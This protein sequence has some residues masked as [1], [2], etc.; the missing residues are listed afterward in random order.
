MENKLQ[1]MKNKSRFIRNLR[2]W[3]IAHTDYDIHIDLNK[4]KIIKPNINQID[5]IL[6]DISD[7]MN[8]FLVQ[9]EKQEVIPFDKLSMTQDGMS[10]I[11]KL[12]KLN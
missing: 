8:Q 4:V 6:T 5:E 2:D 3:I 12:Q 10:I 7:F 9:F 1:K 11:N